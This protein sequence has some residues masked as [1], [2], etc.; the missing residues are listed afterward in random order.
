MQVNTAILD[1]FIRK[2]TEAPKELAR[3]SARNVGYALVIA[4]TSDGENRVIA[5][6][7]D[8]DGNIAFSEWGAG[9]LASTVNLEGFSSAP[10][11][12]SADH[13]RTFQ[14][15]LEKNLP[16]ET[17]PHNRVPQLKMTN[18]AERLRN[19][20]ETILKGYFE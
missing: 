17:Y 19:E 6:T 2:V 12:W 5:S 9:F 20:A 3:E 10:G 11:D 4:D 7:A 13:A 16:P 15:H 14:T 18:E 1:E 8:D